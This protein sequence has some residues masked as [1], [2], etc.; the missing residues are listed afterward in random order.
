MFSYLVDQKNSK[1]DLHIFYLQ[2]FTTYFHIFL[3]IFFSSRTYFSSPG[4][5]IMKNWIEKFL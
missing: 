4:L 1:F 2:D 5:N 3:H